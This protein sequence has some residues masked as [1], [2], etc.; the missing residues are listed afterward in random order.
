MKIY[1]IRGKVL[2]FLY[3]RKIVERLEKSKYFSNIWIINSCVFQAKRAVAIII[4]QNNML[5]EN[6]HTIYSF[7][8]GLS[9][10]L[11]MTR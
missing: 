2:H 7:I 8:Y 1:R 6:Q 3:I 9:V 5:W 11:C 4:C 10:E